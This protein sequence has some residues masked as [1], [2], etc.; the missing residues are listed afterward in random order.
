MA[1][2]NL[3]ILLCCAAVFV[4][5]QNTDE[6]K[7]S[8]RIFGGEEADRGQFKWQVAIGSK[9]EDGFYSPLFSGALIT[10]QW[11]LTNSKID[12]AN[13][14][15]DVILGATH[16]YDDQ[17]GK[18]ITKFEKILFHSEYCYTALGKLVAPVQFTD[19]IG[20]I[21]LPQP[22]DYLAGG[23]TVWFSG[24]GWV[25]SNGEQFVNELRF[26]DLITLFQ[27]NCID[28]DL[29]DHYVCT[30][31]SKGKCPWLYGD[32]GGAL[33]QYINGAWT[34]MATMSTFY[35][36]GCPSGGPTAFTRTTYLLDFIYAN[37]GP[38]SNYN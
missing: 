11:V 27:E 2:I 28:G 26:V 31:G 24:W 3:I 14:E 16:L 4:S 1:T 36:N 20:P 38:I 37:T 17:D 29:P 25:H 21:K 22:T 15:F 35:Y 5:A 18:I 32:E 8:E 33:V 34:H 9:R 10:K 7:P 13:Y 30:D 19:Y 6:A 23:T 12:P